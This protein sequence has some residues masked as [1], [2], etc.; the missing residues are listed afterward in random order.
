MPE[1]GVDMPVWH[2]PSAEKSGNVTAE[3]LR[4]LGASQGI[5]E[6]LLAWQANW[7][8]DPFTGSALHRFRP[9]SPLTVRLA[10]HLQ[11]EL[12]GRRIFLVSESCPRPVDEWLD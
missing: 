3:Q 11:A 12:P 7:D 2:G 9:G 1:H 10:R 8:H 5:I 4:G 6:R